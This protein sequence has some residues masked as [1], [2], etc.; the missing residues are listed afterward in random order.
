MS[1]SNLQ[2][3]S[4][5]SSRHPSA[6]TKRREPIHEQLLPAKMPQAAEYTLI[7]NLDFASCLRR[8]RDLLKIHDGASEVA[9]GSV[10]RIKA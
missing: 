4:S 1:D 3:E 7:R 10:C 2:Q 5:S 6:H 8:L 9:R